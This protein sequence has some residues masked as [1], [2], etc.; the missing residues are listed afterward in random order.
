MT[1]ENHTQK[2]K[3]TDEMLTF[4]TAGAI[5]FY[6]LGLAESEDETEPFRAAIRPLASAH[7]VPTDVVEQ[8][9]ATLHEA[10]AEVA[11]SGENYQQMTAPEVN[12]IRIF[13]PIDGREIV[14]VF[15]TLVDAMVRFDSRADRE[16]IAELMWHLKGIWDIG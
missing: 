9:L 8:T 5:E 11:S 2:L 15:A 13:K 6:A 16:I 7:N 1:T 12:G 4:L 10:C 14:E 3:D